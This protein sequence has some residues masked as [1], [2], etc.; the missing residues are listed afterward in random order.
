MIVSC[1][2][3]N[4]K[5][6]VLDKLI[7]ESGRIL[8]CGSCLHQWHYVPIISL[9][10]E[11]SKNETEDKFK[12]EEPVI[13]DNNIK[14]KIANN[15]QKNIFNQK[16]KINNKKINLN[17]EKKIKFLNL[18]IVGIITFTALIIVIDTF[19]IELSKIIPNVD[20]YLYSFYETVKDIYLF[21]IN[22]IR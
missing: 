8:Q 20:M 4:K 7:P 3:C 19:R 2:K 21:I 11:V 17:K 1:I 13:F 22:L 10:K 12:N 16:K 15:A 6:D 5:F 14:E 18:L 9:V